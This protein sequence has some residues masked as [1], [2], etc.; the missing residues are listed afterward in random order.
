MNVNNTSI[1]IYIDNHQLLLDRMK[2]VHTIMHQLTTSSYNSI[3]NYLNNINI[4]ADLYQEVV[5]DMKD[6]VFVA[7]L[8]QHDLNLF[9]DTVSVGNALSLMRNLLV[10]I[11]RIL[12]I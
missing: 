8:Q 11:K 9:I 1:Q 4:I 3:D 2:S 6:V 7:Y 10:N 5:T 12:D